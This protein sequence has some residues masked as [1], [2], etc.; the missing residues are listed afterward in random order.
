MD[1]AKFICYICQQRLKDSNEAVKHLQS[2]G[3]KNGDKLNCMRDP[4]S[5]DLFCNSS[6][7]SFK[8]LKRHLNGNQCMILCNDVTCVPE[9]ELEK[10]F[11]ELC[12]EES[13]P[14][15]READFSEHFA[16]LIEN[17]I[18]KLNTFNLQHNVFNDVIQITKELI[19]KCTETNQQIIRK[20]PGEQVEFI[21]N[22]T[23][24]FALS[25]I[26]K[27]SSRYKRKSHFEK[28]PY[29]V[30]SQAVQLTGSQ[31]NCTFYY[32]SI[33]KTLRSL[34]ANE[35]FRKAY[36]DYNKDHRCQE[37]VLERYCCGANYQKNSFFK[38]NNNAIQIQIFY[39]DFELTDALKTKTIKVC[40]IYFIIH[41][42]PPKFTSQL[43]NMYLITICDTLVVKKNGI[44]AI[45]EPFV[46]DLHTL[47]TEGILINNETNLKG[48]LV[49]VSFD[50]LG[51]NGIFGFVTS[52]SANHYCRICFCLK[53]E[54][55]TITRETEEK[56]RTAKQYGIKM[57]EIRDL[58]NS[59]SE[60]DFKKTLGYANYCIL[61][62]LKYF[63][64]IDNRSQDLM[65]DIYEGIMPYTLTNLFKYFVTHE[66]LTRAEIANRIRIFDYGKL[67]QQNKPSPVLFTKHSLNQNASQMHCLFKHIPFI[68]ED[69][70]KLKDEKKK[71]KVHNVWRVVEY[72]LKINQIISSTV[73][74][75]TYLKDLENYVEKFL[76][77]YKK[78]FS[79]HLQ[80]KLHFLT[81]YANTIRAMG[82]IIKLSMM[83]GD[84]KHQTFMRYAKRTNNFINIS[85]SLTEKHQLEMVSRLNFNKFADRVESSKRSTKL[86]TELPN[87]REEFIDQAELIKERFENI[88]RVNVRN[89][90]I[91][92]SYYFKKGLFIISSNQIFQI[93]AI[94]E[95]EEAFTFFCSRFRSTKFHKF[96]NSI[97][98]KKCMENSLLDFTELNCQRSYEGKIVNGR[99]LI[100][101]DNLDLLPTYAKF[102]E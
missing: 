81:H 20:N 29:F 27:F 55:Q 76:E 64:T 45:L 48:T 22:S 102:V 25:H 37:G 100:I 88:H 41:N 6:F 17:T 13:S 62:D 43:Q 97:E 58:L 24:D 75:E 16:T 93:E 40:G 5:R 38:N 11:G 101:A 86:C 1:G 18:H 19:S 46:Q 31:I 96:A 90:F 79:T 87:L 57:A 47:E 59:D 69:L 50:N 89:H 54:C 21:L 8:A 68:F 49:Q 80:P 91:F 52:F 32:V 12:F 73:L 39:D 74:T 65:H 85:K 98:I 23:N 33:L 36:F 72:L 51:G 83:R 3:I 71:K 92:N 28:S 42:F 66:I 10:E 84:G 99:T 44:N 70:L 7:H 56:L 26:E 95:Y 2:H 61:N 60:L 35:N 15:E 82:P 53:T 94:L 78:W 30:G 67:E 14:N 34:F 9:F 63:S 4:I 77:S